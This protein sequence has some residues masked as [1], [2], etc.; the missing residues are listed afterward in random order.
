[1]IVE[2]ERKIL[3]DM[4][5]GNGGKLVGAAVDWENSYWGCKK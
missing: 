1:M 3:S 4:G 2:G 5:L